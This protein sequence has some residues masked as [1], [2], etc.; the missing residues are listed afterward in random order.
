MWCDYPALP[1]RSLAA[2][3]RRRLLTWFTANA[4]PLPWRRTRD[5][6]AIWVAEVM[7]QQTQIATVIPYYERFL[8]RF[9]T[10]RSLAAADLQE[11]LGLWAGLGYYRRA[12][13]LH[14]AAQLLLR[15][16]GGSLPADQADFARLPGVGRYTLGAVYSQAFDARLP[17]VDG[18]VQRVL[19]RWGRCPETLTARPA[20][21]WLWAVAE[22]LLPRRR[23]GTF[24]QALMELGQT[25]CTPRQ[26]ACGQCPLRSCCLAWRT[27]ETA[28]L[29]RL[30]ERPRATPILEVAV[31]AR[32]GER[33]LVVQRPGHGRWAHFWEFPHAELTA[34]EEAGAAATRLLKAL[35][36]L[37]AAPL[38]HL[39]TVHHSVTRFR[40]R[41]EAMLMGPPRGRAKRSAQHR[42]LDVAEIG[43]LALSRPQRRLWEMLVRQGA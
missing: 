38:K 27:G 25:I 1:S 17:V 15:D 13:N 16:K 11:V 18:N 19:A 36:G 32:R 23:V 30:P 22:A 20:A 24:N 37:V 4:R 42:W 40:I 29:P 6:Y 14:A 35:T 8:T 39:G 31:L 43:G 3:V 34:G 26:P 9:P 10:V 12:R 7:L 5:P 33:F 2:A 28:T 41:M 21:Q